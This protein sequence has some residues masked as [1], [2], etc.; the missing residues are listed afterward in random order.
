[1]LK[2]ILSQFGLIEEQCKITK[3]GTGLINHTWVIDNGEQKFILQRINHNVFKQ[4]EIIDQNT[5][6]I[7]L[8][9]KKFYPEYL[10]VSA[11][12]TLQ[13][14]TLIQHSN[15]YF[16]LSNFIKDSVTITTVAN[17]EQAYEAAKQFGRFT[18]LLSDFNLKNLGITLPD[19]HNLTLRFKQFEDAITNGNPDRVKQ[20]QDEI[21]KLFALKDIVDTYNN[22]IGNNTIP[23]RVIH[24]DTKISNVL[25]DQH[26]KGLCVIDL[27]TVMPGYF[28][29][30]VGDMMRTYLSPANE[31]VQ[32]LNQVSV[33]L[34][35]FRAIFEGYM[36]E[37][38]D[39]LT[40]TE[41]ELFIYSG[42]FIIYMQALR[43][44]TDYLNNDTYYGAVYPEHNLSRA[45]NQ[46]KLLEEYIGAEKDF[47]KII[48]ASVSPGV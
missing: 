30:D 44:L 16:R 20:T 29:S 22:I 6:S 8:F 18:A 41:K 19:F 37:L 12:P 26:G 24:H 33:R 25:F 46:I 21:D 9:F 5:S 47:E 13:G 35:M 17:A 43:F 3:L 48:N 7:D 23:L 15:G 40:A 32:D 11:V 28:I 38:S 27:D 4:P 10:F 45:K 42:K 36:S 34:E 1:M 39:K 14:E 2:D 31:E